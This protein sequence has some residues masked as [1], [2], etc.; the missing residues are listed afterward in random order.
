MNTY[1]KPIIRSE[2]NREAITYNIN[3]FYLFHEIILYNILIV[4]YRQT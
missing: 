3:Y 1:C 2:L 4:Y